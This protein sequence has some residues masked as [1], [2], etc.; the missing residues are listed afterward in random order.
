MGM[1]IEQNCTI[2]WEDGSTES[3]EVIEVPPQVANLSVGGTIF[4]WSAVQELYRTR[5]DPVSGAFETLERPGLPTE[6]NQVR[7]TAN[8]VTRNGTLGA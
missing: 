2:T 7:R 6:P 5:R 4:I 3:V 1:Q 8:G